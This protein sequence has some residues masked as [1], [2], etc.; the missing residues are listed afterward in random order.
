MMDATETKGIRMT[1]AARA[2]A[3][4][5]ATGALALA[6]AGCTGSPEPAPAPTT[7]TSAAPQ[8]TDVTDTP[9]SGENLVGALEDAEVASC[10]RDGDDW[11]VAGTV[12][13]GA[14]ATADYRIYVSLLNA[15]SETRALS[16]VDVAAVAAGE[17]AEWSVE[18]PMPEDDLDCVLRVERYTA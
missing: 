7:S 9:G 16:Q 10:E 2:T 11:S 8:V 13:N 5:L 14:D 6:L 4:I 12:T 18:I 17:S 3:A 15:A 1:S